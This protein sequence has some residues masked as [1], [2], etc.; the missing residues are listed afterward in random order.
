MVMFNEA[1]VCNI[2]ETIMFG[3]TACEA[4]EEASIDLVDYAVRHLTLLCSGDIKHKQPPKHV[5]DLEQWKPGDPLPDIGP[6]ESVSDELNRLRDEVTFQVRSI[7]Q[8]WPLL[9]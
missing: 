2:L 6:E 3:P 9:I 1:N 4:L 7:L 8:L 5:Q